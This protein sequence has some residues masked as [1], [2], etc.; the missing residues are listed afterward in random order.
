MS[1]WPT[2][3]RARRRLQTEPQ[4]SPLARPRKPFADASNASTAIRNATPV[5]HAL[6]RPAHMRSK[7]LSCGTVYR[8]ICPP[9]RTNRPAR[10]TCCGCM[11]HVC[12]KERRIEPEKRPRC[13][14]VA[15]L[16]PWPACLPTSA[17]FG[18]RVLAWLWRVPAGI[19]RQSRK[20]S[21]QALT[22]GS[23]RRTPE[24]RQAGVRLRMRRRERSR[25]SH[26]CTPRRTRARPRA[27]A[28]LLPHCAVDGG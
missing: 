9:S 24:S 26:C 21:W 22:H 2:S 25:F 20:F 19:H 14:N 3:Q 12:Q 4:I 1:S 7:R 11:S 10:E 8:H 18:S 5:A 27:M 13:V 17:S 6:P 28:C 15:S 23:A 16:E